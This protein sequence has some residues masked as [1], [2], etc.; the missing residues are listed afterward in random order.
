MKSRTKKI[1]AASVCVMFFSFLILAAA[2]HIYTGGK[3]PVDEDTGACAC[4]NPD[5]FEWLWLEVGVEHGRTVNAVYFVAEPKNMVIPP[6]L[7]WIKH[8][9]IPFIPPFATFTMWGTPDVIGIF[10]CSFD[11]YPLGHVHLVFEIWGAPA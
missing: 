7:G 8:A 11:V 9:V 6:E 2:S 4:D 3:R 10:L 1:A 5:Y